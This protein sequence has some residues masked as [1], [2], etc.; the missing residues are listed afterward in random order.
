MTTLRQRLPAA[1]LALGLGLSVGLAMASPPDAGER[2][3][4]TDRD[5]DRDT[6]AHTNGACPDRDCHGPA[7]P[8]PDAQPQPDAGDRDWRGGFKRRLRGS[9]ERLSAWCPA[10]SLPPG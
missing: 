4:K 10:Y 5:A 7:Q 8:A 3:H 6:G 2:G 1:V 9:I